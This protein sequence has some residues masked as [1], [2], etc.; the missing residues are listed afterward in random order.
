MEQY[1][2][3]CN[4]PA[5]LEASLKETWAKIDTK[6]EGSVTHEQFKVACEQIAKTMNLPGMHPPTEEEKA[7]AKKLVDPNNTGKINFEGFKALINAGIAKARKEGK[8]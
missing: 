8:L 7:A 1:K 4:D 6:G 5:K 2:A 3:I